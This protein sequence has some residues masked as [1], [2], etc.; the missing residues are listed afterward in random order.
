MKNLLIQLKYTF[1]MSVKDRSFI[2]WMIAFPIILCTAFYFAFGNIDKEAEIDI[3][4]GLSQNIANSET[5]ESI[6][7]QVPLFEVIKDDE[8]MLKE[9]L[10]NKEL[11][12]YLDR[13]YKL[14]VFE[15]TTNSK[16]AV[17]IIEEMQKY[18]I[19]YIISKNDKVN[20]GLKTPDIIGYD[21]KDVVPYL[22]EAYKSKDFSIMSSAFGFTK[23]V[24]YKNGEASVL[25]TILFTSFGM[26]SLYGI[27]ICIY[28]MELIQG[29]LSPLAVRVSVAPYKKR[30]LIIN[31]FIS[32][33]ILTFIF[34]IITMLYVKYILGVTLFN[35]LK[36][37]FLVLVVANIFGNSLGILF[38]ISKKFTSEQKSGL[39]TAFLLILSFMCGMGGSADLRQRIEESVPILNRLNPVNLINECLY[40]VNII[41]NTNVLFRNLNILLLVGLIILIISGIIL[42]RKSYDSL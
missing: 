32:G 4:F 35:D 21:F 20:L 8:K 23:Y 39:V 34:N 17:N 29:Y 11:D 16:I 5:M 13:D 15:S 14:I 41:E 40:Q 31:A 30:N 25:K 36:L 24:E 6:L 1:L 7:A 19:S 18:G 22:N 12:V 42:R 37:T 3:K 26:F 9:K 2:F 27:Y 33:F 28:L 10:L 38:G